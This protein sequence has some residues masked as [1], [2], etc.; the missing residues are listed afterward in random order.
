M[1]VLVFVVV[2]IL[3]LVTGGKQSQIVLQPTKVELK[4]VICLEFCF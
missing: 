3:V 4:S 2:A 1:L